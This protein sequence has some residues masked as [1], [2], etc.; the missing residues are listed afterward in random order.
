M[1]VIQFAFDTDNRNP[2]LPQNVLKNTIYYMGTHDNNTFMGFLNRLNRA[3]LKTIDDYLGTKSLT[4]QQ[5]QINVI[6]SMLAS[7]S[8]IIILQAQDFMF[9]GEDFRMNIPGVAANCWEYR[10]PNNYKF[11]IKQ[12]LQKIRR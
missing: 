3:Q 8:D 4:K 10:L 9:E 11:R 2:H 7:K 12:T 6:N 5:L 1:N